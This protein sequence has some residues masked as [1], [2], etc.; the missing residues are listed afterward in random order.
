MVD[1][2]V[3]LQGKIFPGEIT[4][5]GKRTAARFRQRHK[6]RR[7]LG[8]FVA[9][10]HPDFGDRI[11]QGAGQQRFDLG[12]TIFAVRRGVHFTAQGVSQRLHPVTNAQ[13]R[14]AG[15]KDE[16]LE[17][18]RA[19]FVDGLWP[20]RKDEGLGLD[21]HDFFL[22]RIPRE[23]FAVDLRLAHAARDDL[24]VLGTKIENGN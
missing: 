17:K 16:G 21:G 19:R 1:F 5:G 13:N 14:Q 15:F 7:Q 8:D 9:V 10:R 22:R 2:G 24:G 20:T 23:K 6:A 3:E 11:E 4:H 12:V 18:G